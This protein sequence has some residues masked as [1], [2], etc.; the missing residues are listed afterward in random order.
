MASQIQ[1][2]MGAQMAGA[3]LPIST[4]K[5]N[6][7]VVLLALEN[8]KKHLKTL[9]T[10]GEKIQHKRG[11]IP[12]WEA[13]KDNQTVFQHLVLWLADVG[14][15]GEFINHVLIAIKNDIS[16]PN[17]IK[18]DWATFCCD[19]V[20]DWAETQ[21]KAG[22]SIEPHFST[23]IE[24]LEKD[25]WLVHEKVAAK[26]FK[27]HGQQ[28]LRDET[29]TVNCASVGNIDALETALHY[30]EKANSLHSKIG[31]GELIGVRIPQRIRA[32]KEN[33]NL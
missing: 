16:T 10:I 3:T 8:D 18:R 32:L 5:H 26:L 4:P 29:G 1:R 21:A 20:F 23:I 2:L 27:L 31:V 7:D 17:F 19:V 22:Q 13:Y 9:K 11:L 33:K 24:K 28:F 6:H 30:L 12:K 14:E 15:I 25:E